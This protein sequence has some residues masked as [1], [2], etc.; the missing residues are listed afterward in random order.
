MRSRCSSVSRSSSLLSLGRYGRAS[1]TPF[2]RYSLKPL[3]TRPGRART[4]VNALPD[5]GVAVVSIR[6]TSRSV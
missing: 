4:L 5:P 2:A 3:T 1:Q 6:P